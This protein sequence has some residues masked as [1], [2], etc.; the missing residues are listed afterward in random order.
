[1]EGSPLLINAGIGKC[2]E[3]STNVARTPA[4]LPPMLNIR[5]SFSENLAKAAHHS[6]GQLYIGDLLFEQGL[7]AGC[8]ENPRRVAAQ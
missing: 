3:T 1:V 4:H 6:D 2:P 5:D 7:A 8:V